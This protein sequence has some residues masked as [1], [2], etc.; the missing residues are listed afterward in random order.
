MSNRIGLSFCA[1]S[2]LALLLAA[3]P[4]CLAQSSNL[5]GEHGFG[6]GFEGRGFHGFGMRA[7]VTGAPYSALRTTTIVKTLAD[8]ST[9]THVIQ[10]KEAR[11]SSG[12]TYAETLPSAQAGEGPGRSFVRVF[13]PVNRVSISWSANTRQA[14]LVHLPELGQA[15]NP[16]EPA[17]DAAG[18]QRF[19]DS[20]QAVTKE[21]L[22]S[23]T[24]NGLV[25][26]G[27]RTTRVIPAGAHGNSEALTITHEEWVSPDL[28]VEVERVETDP[29][30]GT[31]TVEVTN[32]SR[33]EPS[34]ALFQ[35][36]AGYRVKEMTISG[37]RGGFEAAP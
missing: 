17:E 28:K 20:N 34:A 30:F 24:I 18:V 23:K 27:T 9:I 5:A 16:R 7:P 6:P 4:A 31:T 19:R 25:A 10:V 21:S 2:S 12:R 37:R 33:E 32:L 1:V 14:T 26:E 22:G 3:A 13:D 35:T 36:P 8:G 29:R 15:S 11:D